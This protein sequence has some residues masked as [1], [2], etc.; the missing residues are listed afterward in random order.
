M[1]DHQLRVDRSWM[2]WSDDAPPPAELHPEI[3]HPARMYDYYLGGKDNFPADRAA[4]EQLLS[5]SPMVRVAARANRDFLQRAVRELA[6]LG[7]RRFIDVGT[8][9]P[10]AGNTHETAQQVH[11]E[12][13]VVYLD[14]DPIVLVHS[15]ALLSGSTAGCT[16]VVQADL[17][18]PAVILQDPAVQR[19]LAPGEP[20]ALLLFAILHFVDEADDP[21]AIVRELV[22]ALPPGSYLALSHGTADFLPP[23]ERGLGPAVYRNAS[24][25][26]TLRGKDQVARFFDGLEL[27][28]PGLVTVAQ[29]RPDQPP[30]QTDAQV[31]IWAAIGRKP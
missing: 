31:G 29:W 19:L 30:A 23:E 4:A 3:P 21:H 1:T 20:V 10:T 11:P 27:V 25:Q 9:I 22:R 8:G 14:N 7:V 26:L 15:R 28:D 12:S 17:R 24:A 18:E 16:T 6:G 2:S 5:S 13:Q